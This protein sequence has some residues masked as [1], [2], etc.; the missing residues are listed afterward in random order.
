MNKQLLNLITLWDEPCCIC[1]AMKN[2]AKMKSRNNRLDFKM[3]GKK[4]RKVIDVDVFICDACIKAH[5]VAKMN[6][7]DIIKKLIPEFHAVIKMKLM[8]ECG[9]PIEKRYVEVDSDYE[10]T[11]LEYAPDD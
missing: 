8:G 4:Q 9:I 10:W 3:L 7:D 11:N 1:L 5:K 2:D 6:E